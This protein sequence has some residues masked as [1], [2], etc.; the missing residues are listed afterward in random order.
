[1]SEDRELKVMES[2]V[3]EAAKD[4]PEARDA[5]IKLFP[6][7]FKEEWEDVTRECH[8]G[9]EKGTLG[10]RPPGVHG[11]VWFFRPLYLR[12]NDEFR[13]ADDDVFRSEYEFKVEDGRIWRRK[14]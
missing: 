4:C 9:F 8:L 1:M 14:E 11:V 3:L 10:I 7:A 5:L 12:R 13:W 2:R 6:D